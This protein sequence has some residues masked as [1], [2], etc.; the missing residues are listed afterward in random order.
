[1]NNLY[2]QIDCEEILKRLDNIQPNAVRQWGKMDVSQMLAHLN[3]FLETS[4]GKKP[5]KRMLIGRI[6]GRF[7]VRRYVSEKQFSKNGPTGKNYIITNQQNFEKEKTKAIQLIGQFYEIGPEK[8]TK[9]PHPFFGYL[10]PNEWAIA[11][12]KH[13]DHH[14]RQFGV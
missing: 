4:L 7:F 8:C 5:Q 13:F 10:T 9:L 6:L 12:W 3:A 11:Q 2:N 14:L 1:M